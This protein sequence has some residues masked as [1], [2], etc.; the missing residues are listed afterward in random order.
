VEDYQSKS[1]IVYKALE[2]PALCFGLPMQ[3][4]FVVTAVPFLLG[5]FFSL[6]IWIL[7]PIIVFFLGLLSRKDPHIYNLLYLKLKTTGN[8]KA[9]LYY[10]ATA[11][12]AQQ[13]RPIELKRL[14]FINKNDK[15]E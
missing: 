8:R 4:L 2:R 15:I 6:L 1:H 11:I 5:M 13:Y 3:M 7:I 10:G 9:N 14:L 12:F